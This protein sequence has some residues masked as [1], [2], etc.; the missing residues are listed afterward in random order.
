MAAPTTPPPAT[1]PPAD[2]PATPPPAD[3]PADPGDGPIP[4]ERLNAVIAQRDEARSQLAAAGVKIEAYQ[5]MAAESQRLQTA[6]ADARATMERER[7]TYQQDR[8]FLRA[9]IYDDDVQALVRMKHGKAGEG[10][11]FAAFLEAEKSKPY[12]SPFLGRLNAEPPPGQPAAPPTTAPPAAPPRQGDPSLKGNPTTP[13]PASE[14]DPI[15]IASMS[16]ADYRNSRDAILT[17]VL[18]RKKAP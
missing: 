3:P 16:L 2:P 7:A 4:R 13:S 11:D 14:Y 5:A 15:A 6:L 1:P 9:G 18:G 10:T 12:L 17:S 8:V